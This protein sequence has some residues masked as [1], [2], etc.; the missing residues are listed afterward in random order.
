M[1]CFMMFL[2]HALT[3]FTV[4][5]FVEINYNTIFGIIVIDF[6]ICAILFLEIILSFR[7][8]VI[9]KETNEIILD[10]LLIA[11]K[12]GKH[13]IFDVINLLPYIYLTTFIVDIQKTM[14][15]GAVVLYMVAL[16][17]YYCF[18]FNRMIFY[19]TSLPLMLNLTEKSSIILQ[20]IIRSSFLLHMAT[21]VRRLVPLYAF[22]A[23]EHLSAIDFKSHG[24]PSKYAVSINVEEVIEEL[25]VIEKFLITG[26]ADVFHNYTMFHMYAR[27]LLITLKTSIQAG[28]GFETSDSI[29]IMIMST[30]IMIG[31]WIYAAYVKAIIFNL[32]VATSI[33]ENKFEEM[34]REMEVFS[35]SK[36]LSEGLRDRIRIFLKRKYQ[37]H[38][39]NEI[40]IKEST[41]TCLRKEIMMNKCS[42]LVGRVP[43]FNQIP[44]LLLEKIMNC[45]QFEIY[46]PGDIIIQANAV[47]DS[48]YFI[49]YGTASI[50][51]LGGLFKNQ[52]I[53]N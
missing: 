2:H 34:M 15:N 40:A 12:Y 41:P 37:K 53:S 24:E 49:A 11:K 32:I 18:Y 43:L 28:Y 6:I 23:D 50:S 36:G 19:F 7:T 52:L 25:E 35:N 1:I 47:G 14:V 21:C 9:V 30:L 39:F 42:N 10:P 13:V 17:I 38:Y 20:I 44:P 48:M 5:F 4:G 22:H 29:M 16:M 31:G 33:S 8:G 51:S 26:L 45:L 27:S 3:A 46:F